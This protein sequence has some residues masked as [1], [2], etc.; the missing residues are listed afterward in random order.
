MVLTTP[1]YERLAPLNETQLWSHWSGYLAA[2]KYQPAA[3]FEYFAVRNSAGL[4][5]TS[6]LYKYRFGGRDAAKFLGRVLARDINACRDGQA[7]Y[8]LWLDERGYVVEDGVVIRFAPDELILTTAEPNLAYFQNLIGYEQVEITDVSA[9]YA[10]LAVQGPRSREILASLDP[11]IADLA[12]F[13]HG[14][15]KLGN[16]PVHVSRTGYTGDLG[17]ELWVGADGALE[18]WDTL[19]DACAGRGVL[20]VGQNALLMT[21]IEA[22]LI[23]IGVDFHSSRFAFN[24]EQCSTP[25]ELGFGWMFRDLAASPRQFIGRAAVERELAA[26]TSRWKMVGLMVD[27]KDWDRHYAG[28]GLIPPKDETPVVYEMM[29]YDDEGNRVGYTTSFMYSPMLQRH[30]AMARVRPDLGVTG[31]RV[32]L[33]V[34]INHRYHT[35]AAE[36]ARPPLFNPPRK[37]A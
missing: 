13:H 20:P 1:F 15:A 28:A 26:R 30:I 31:T 23:L 16:V 32:N 14:P 37:T 36:V 4:I 11:A 33:E 12:F 19:A 5:D 21:R 18:M 34:T 3:K 24:D 9:E 35:V 29:L 8:T 22:G 25:I 17:Y 6:P 27:W 7:Q 2:V 10:S